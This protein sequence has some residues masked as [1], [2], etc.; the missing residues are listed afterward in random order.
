MTNWGMGKGCNAAS[1]VLT[2]FGWEVAGEVQQ[3][4]ERSL[5]R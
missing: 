3:L 2:H 5:L 1:R 4:V